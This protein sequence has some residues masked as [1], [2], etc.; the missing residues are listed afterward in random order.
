M[1]SVTSQQ[2][3]TRSKEGERKEGSGARETKERAEDCEE[4]AISVFSEEEGGSIYQRLT[5]KTGKDGEERDQAWKNPHKE[6][7]G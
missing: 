3:T 2:D 5:H 1:E 4:G 7:R 6:G